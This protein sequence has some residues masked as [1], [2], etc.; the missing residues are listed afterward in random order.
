MVHGFSDICLTQGPFDMCE[1]ESP[2]IFPL[3]LW[4][5][6]IALMAPGAATL[7]RSITARRERSRLE[8]ILQGIG[9][10]G[11]LGAIG[12]SVALGVAIGLM[13]P[14]AV[15]PAD[16]PAYETVLTP[17]A[18][19]V[20]LLPAIFLWIFVVR[21]GR[22]RIAVHGE[23]NE[24][25][26]SIRMLRMILVLAYGFMVLPVALAVLGNG[27]ALFWGVAERVGP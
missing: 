22:M 25:R 20:A 14:V 23:A 9:A 21:A 19:F 27:I 26:A 12:W 16:Q 13:L 4:I 2:L 24:S 3:R 7:A 17:A 10:A 5:V 18:M 6:L 1:V 11:V 8:A 15:T